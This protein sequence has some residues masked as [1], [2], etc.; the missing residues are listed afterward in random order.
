MHTEGK[1]TRHARP[2]GEQIL[3]HRRESGPGSGGHTGRP[4]EKTASGAV[5][6]RSPLRQMPPEV[7]VELPGQ[8]VD[9]HVR[10]R[11]VLLIQLGQRP[12]HGLVLGQRDREADLVDGCK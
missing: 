4:Y 12:G 3:N 10:G 5:C 2:Y 11:A 6:P 8:S 9:I 1:R 7:L